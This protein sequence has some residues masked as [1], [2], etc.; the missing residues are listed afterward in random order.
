MPNSSVMLN[1]TQILKKQV[2]VAHLQVFLWQYLI[3]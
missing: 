2:M 3:T 1:I